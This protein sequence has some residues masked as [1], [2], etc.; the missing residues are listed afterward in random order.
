METDISNTCVPRWLR[1]VRV[2]SVIVAALFIVASIFLA[3]VFSRLDIA[4]G[5][6]GCAVSLFGVALATRIY[7]R[8]FKEARDAAA[9]T[10]EKLDRLEEQLATS[11]SVP[12][13]EDE[14][15][16]ANDEVDDGALAGTE[17][18]IF[19]VGDQPGT[20]YEAAEVP[21]SVLGNLVWGW[22][23]LEDHAN[24]DGRWAVKNLVGAWRPHAASG[25]GR[26]NMP[27]YVTFRNS[28]GERQV[29]RV[30]RGGR[31]KS[32]P[33]VRNVT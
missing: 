25:D 18:E 6:L 33:T 10:H 9:R 2:L 19:S 3:V 26:G 16:A 4:V 11:V 28:R 29:W 23:L 30:Y 22:R 17:G 7:D 14:R 1:P 32:E 20:L 21:L 31:N 24:S 5:V 27:W 15:Q 8:Q 13:S 12:L